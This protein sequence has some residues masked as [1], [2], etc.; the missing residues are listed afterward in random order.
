ME[1]DPVKIANECLGKQENWE[2]EFEDSIC[3]SEITTAGIASLIS[4]WSLL[5]FD[6][7]IKTLFDKYFKL[8]CVTETNKNLE[9]KVKIKCRKGAILIEEVKR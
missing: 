7:N 3:L 6:K 9:T 8:A 5:L 2:E 1:N 4:E